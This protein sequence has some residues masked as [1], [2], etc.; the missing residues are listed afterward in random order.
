LG[1]TNK[2]QAHHGIAEMMQFNDEQVRFH[3][4]NQRRFSM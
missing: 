3:R 1:A 2:R 4:A